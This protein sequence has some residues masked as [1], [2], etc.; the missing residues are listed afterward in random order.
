MPWVTGPESPRGLKGRENPGWLEPS[1][2]SSRGLTG[3][4]GLLCLLPQG[5]GLRPQPWAGLCRPVGPGLSEA[6][7]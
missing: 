7:R 6:L 2:Q 1:E 4:C 3:R 5:I